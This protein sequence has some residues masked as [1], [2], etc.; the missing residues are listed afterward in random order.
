MSSCKTGVVSMGRAGC[1]CGQACEGWHIVY[2]TVERYREEWAE[3]M[4]H[5]GMNRQVVAGKKRQN[6]KNGR[7]PGEAGGRDMRVAWFPL[8]C[9]SVHARASVAEHTPQTPVALL[10]ATTDGQWC[11]KN[12]R[13]RQVREV[14]ARQ[15]GVAPVRGARVYAARAAAKRRGG[16]AQRVAR[17]RVCWQRRVV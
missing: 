11:R 3:V 14:C 16:V 1:I 12:G 4:R 5:E 6:D 10:F 15:R 7:R 8:P 9:H 2:I 13:R 17:V